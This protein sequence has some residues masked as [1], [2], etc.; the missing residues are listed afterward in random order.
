MGAQGKGIS[1]RKVSCV[2]GS[3]DC[4]LKLCHDAGKLWRGLPGWWDIFS[5]FLGLCGDI[6]MMRFVS[7][8]KATIKRFVTPEVMSSFF[9]SPGINEDH[10]CNFGNTFPVR[11]FITLKTK[12]YRRLSISGLK[13]QL[14]E[15]DY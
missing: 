7:Y 11:V 10:H 2:W 6:C 13:N 8:V 5:G 14:Y 15:L 1:V 12:H 3:V 4:T 9:I